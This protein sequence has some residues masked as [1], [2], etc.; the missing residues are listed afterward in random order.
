MN[1]LTADLD[2]L[3]A[4]ETDGSAD[5]VIEDAIGNQVDDLSVPLQDF[6]RLLTIKDVSLQGATGIAYNLDDPVSGNYED[7]LTAA[8]TTLDD[9]AFH[10]DHRGN[11]S[12]PGFFNV[13]TCSNRVIQDQG[14]LFGLQPNNFF[15]NPIPAAVKPERFPVPAALRGSRDRKLE[16]CACSG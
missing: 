7:F 12:L 4:E 5:C 10:Q 14:V 9:G 1:A 15:Y 3:A 11:P 13:T 6:A 8:H 16:S 2:E